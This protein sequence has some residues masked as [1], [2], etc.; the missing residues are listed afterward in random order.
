MGTPGNETLDIG[1]W[2]SRIDASDRQIVKLL[3]ERA[4][5]VSQLIPLKAQA[6]RGVR[7]PAR[8]REVLKKLTSLNRGPLPDESVARIYEAIMAEMRL[9]QERGR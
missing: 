4:G 2:R 8:E 3:N 6:Q 5:H 7:D 9:L 1:Y